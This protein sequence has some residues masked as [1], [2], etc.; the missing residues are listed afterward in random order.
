MN[1]LARVI[2]NRHFWIVAVMLAVCTLFHYLSPQI[3]LPLQVSFPL[4]RQ[5]VVRI[6]FLLPVAAATFAF[7]Q[8]GGL[9][10]LAAAILLMLPRVFFVS[11]QPLDALF[12]T[13]SVGVVGYIVVWMIETQEKEKR[14][15]QRAVEELEAVNAIALTLT[16]PYD[17]EAM[18]DEALSRVLQVVG[19]LEP[20]GAIFV[21]DPWGQVLRL[22]AHRGMAPRFVEQEQ[23]I[24]LGECLCG[25]AAKSGEVLVVHDALNHPL[26]TRCPDPEPHSHVCVPLKSKERLLGVMDFY[27]DSARELATA[28][29]EMFA[30][31]G[32]QMGVAIENARLYE[33]LR[34]YVRQITRV[35]ED[36]RKRVARELHDDTAQGLIDL[37]RRLDD[38]AATEEGLSAPATARLELLRQQIEGILQGV[39]RFSRDL[40]PSVLD[41]LG[42]LPALEGLLDDL[43]ESEIGTE[44]EISGERRRLSSEVELELFRIVQEALNNVKRHAQASEAVIGVQFGE[45]RVRVTVRDDGRGFERLGSTSDFVTMGKFG[46]VGMEERAHLL[47]GYFAVTAG[48]A[49]GVIVIVDVPA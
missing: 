12:E 19:G 41:D 31:I 9:T 8:A 4:T 22:R 3:S 11:A 37:S 28:D 10:A 2:K 15:R 45:G 33:N 47:G 39:R 42:L 6:I 17:L 27:L 30:A 5:A 16:K 25:L 26:H 36:E 14:L 21:L 34:F 48:E 20:K 13:A 49:G 44:L 46:L 29:K 24:P 40:R 38:L 35:Q 7:G 18:L 23:E 43:E 32:R 1:K